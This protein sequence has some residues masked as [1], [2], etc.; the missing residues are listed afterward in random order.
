[1]DKQDP[2]DYQKG[3]FN[4]VRVTT[5][6][7]W[8]VGDKDYELNLEFLKLKGPASCI[9][10]NAVF[11]SGD[12]T[13][14]RWGN[15]PSTCTANRVI[16]PNRWESFALPCD[17]GPLNQAQQ[18]FDDLAAGSYDIRWVVYRHDA[19]SNIYHA[20]AA[21]D[22]MWPGEG[23]W[24][25]T[26]DPSTIDYPGHVNTTDELPLAADSQNG[27]LNFV[28][29]HHNSTIEWPDAQAVVGSAT[30]SVSDA[31]PANNTPPPMAR[32]C[33]MVPA[34]D[35]CLLSRIMYKWSG[36]NYDAFNGE[37]PGL[38]GEFLPG[39]AFWV[40]A[41]RPGVKLRVR[42]TPAAVQAAEYVKHQQIVAS[43]QEKKSNSTGW[44]I[45][46]LARS[47]NKLDRGNVLGQLP[48][49]VDGVDDNDV[50][51]PVPFSNS[52][53]SLVFE[54]PRFPEVDW[55]Y[56]S[57]F[58]ATTHKPRGTWSILVR[59]SSDVDEITLSWEG[60]DKLFRSARLRDQQTGKLIPVR[61]GGSY[62]FV[63]HGGENRLSL[64]FR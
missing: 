18:I 25:Y 10:A 62:T 2:A 45:R 23:Y 35:D 14:G 56:T 51:E 22:L 30:E 9:E 8:L 7:Y 55:G 63:N 12:I 36:S 3:L 38:E 1:M 58:R 19:S 29:N 41:F 37:T 42:E 43:V 20:L 5:N 31:D 32:E 39:D 44:H 34:G 47:G 48:N 21:D 53:L 6:K 13:S 57:D 26:L 27:K 59:A 11:S 28:E 46:L 49:S 17:P 60:Q 64:V 24:I 61:P 33:D 50:E 54:N 4:G 52:Y 15:C 40:R 16:I